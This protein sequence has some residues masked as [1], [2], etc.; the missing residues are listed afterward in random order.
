MMELDM[1]LIDDRC[2][3]AGNYSIFFC[4]KIPCLCMEEKGVP[5]GELFLQFLD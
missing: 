2:N 3:S 1:P 5:V 4:K